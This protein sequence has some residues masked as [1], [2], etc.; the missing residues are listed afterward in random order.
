MYSLANGDFSFEEE[1]AFALRIEMFVDY[2]FFSYVKPLYCQIAEGWIKAH[3]IL[4]LQ[5]SQKQEFILVIVATFLQKYIH[6]KLISDLHL[7]RGAKC[8]KL[9]A[10]RVFL[11]SLSFAFCDD[12]VD[13]AFAHQRLHLKLL[14]A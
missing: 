6:S 12:F 11:L 7:N 2:L 5:V 8:A 3:S 9:A 14:H 4:L 1:V 10:I 13:S